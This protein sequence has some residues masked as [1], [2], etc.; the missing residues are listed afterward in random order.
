MLLCICYDIHIIVQDNYWIGLGRS[1]NG[2][3]WVDGSPFDF[4]YWLD[5]EPN[6][7]DNDE[8]CVEV[9]SCIVHVK[10]EMCSVQ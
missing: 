3:G 1:G 10:C 4:P 5:G 6:G 8:D 7:A 9:Y 2:F